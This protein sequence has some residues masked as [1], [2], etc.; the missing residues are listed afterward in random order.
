MSAYDN[1]LAAPADD[2]Q[3]CRCDDVCRCAE[4]QE[5]QDE[6]AAD[7]RLFNRTLDEEND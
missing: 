6:A 5:A 7:L 1:W 3:P 2:V 4:L